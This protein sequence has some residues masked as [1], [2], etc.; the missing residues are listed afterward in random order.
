MSILKSAKPEGLKACGTS[1]RA[2]AS[3]RD[4]SRCPNSVKRRVK[5]RLNQFIDVF[6]YHSVDV[7]M[8]TCTSTPT[9]AFLNESTRPCVELT[10]SVHIN[11]GMRYSANAGLSDFST[12]QVA[13]YEYVNVFV[14]DCIDVLSYSTQLRNDAW[15]HRRTQASSHPLRRSVMVQS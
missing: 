4:A 6:V 12:V 10:H 5:E 13:M 9:N 1:Y 2:R 15:I 7:Q 11:V 14:H 3:V 8:L